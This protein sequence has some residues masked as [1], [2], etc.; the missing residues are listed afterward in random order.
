MQYVQGS[1]LREK[2]LNKSG[3]NDD[4]LQITVAELENIINYRLKVA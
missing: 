2:Y 1:I 3:D 4:L